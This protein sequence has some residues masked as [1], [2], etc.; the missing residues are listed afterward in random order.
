LYDRT[1]DRTEQHDVSSQHPADV[2]RNIATLVQWVDAQNKIRN[3]IGHTGTT[4][5]DQRTLERL[6]SLGYLGGS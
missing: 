1:T 5:L 6:R 4:P 3:I 2:E